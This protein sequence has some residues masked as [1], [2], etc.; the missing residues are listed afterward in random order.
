MV[1]IR[2]LWKSLTAFT[3]AVAVGSSVSLGWAA[4]LSATDQALPELGSPANEA[5]SLE[6]EY[7]AGLGWFRQMGQGGA[8][9]EAPEVS[10]YIQQIGPKLSSCHEEGQNQFYYFV[11]RDPVI[12]AF[13]M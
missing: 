3:A 8:V 7:Q 12:N 2:K 11:V 13:T 4:G 1:N 5:V 6:D 9:M 10:S